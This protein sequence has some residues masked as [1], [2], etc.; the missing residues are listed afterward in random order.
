MKT[1]QLHHQLTASDFFNLAL[2]TPENKSFVI[3]PQA[4][5]PLQSSLLRTGSA[6][7]FRRRA[8]YYIEQS[9]RSGRKKNR[10]ITLPELSDEQ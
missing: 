2:R 3:L 6:S 7:G 5:V 10:K 9:E 8:P 1:A 4:F